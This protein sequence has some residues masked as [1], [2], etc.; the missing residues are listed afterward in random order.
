MNI[1]D[2]Y[3][4]RTIY[5]PNYL[6]VGF[7]SLIQTVPWNKKPI[8]E[9]YRLL[10]RKMLSQSGER[11]LISSIIP[12]GVGHI[13]S[14]KSYSL[15]NNK[16]LVTISGCFNSIIY[17]YYLKSTGINNF[18]NS[19][20]ESFPYPSTD[21]RIVNAIKVRT[22][23]LNFVNKSYMPIWE[24]VWDNSFKLEKWTKIHPSLKQGF[25]NN[26]DNTWN[27]SCVLRNEY[28]RRW[29]LI[30]IDVLVALALE[31]SLNE[32][33]D[34]FRIQFNV[35]KNNEKNTY[36]D[37]N[38]LYVFVKKKGYAEVGFSRPEWN[39]IKDMPSGTVERKI[40]DDTMPGGPV[41]RTITYEAPF[42]R[43]D[44]EEDYRIAWAEFEKRLG[45]V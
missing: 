23:C 37:I 13:Y 14:S 17:D 15:P 22:A 4:P 32:L 40:I 16:R 9:L 10:V 27:K 38:G 39:E 6:K 8:T 20:F 28:E 18:G 2:N 5:Q 35:L 36:Y 7:D 30:E 25:F 21:I 31:L 29:A 26:L 24:E 34:I 3:F 42:D 19:Q 45:K 33:L 12:P 11:T 44:R 43:C 1:P 41:E